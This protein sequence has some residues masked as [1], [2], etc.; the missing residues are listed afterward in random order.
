MKVLLSG[1]VSL[2]FATPV[3]A[4]SVKIVGM[5][6]ATCARFMEETERTPATERDYFAW[7][8]GYMSGI[9]ISAPPELDERVD[10]R[11]PTFR[12]QQQ[13]DFLRQYCDQNRE[14]DYS[15]GVLA[16]Y[17]KLGGEAGRGRRS[18]KE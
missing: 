12:L 8:Q 2:L 4:Q 16:L 6:A 17:R 5:G 14:T 7:A 13:A 9:I 10:L 11:P 1:I 15:D 3:Y 18:G